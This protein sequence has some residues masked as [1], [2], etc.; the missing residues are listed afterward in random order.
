MKLSNDPDLTTSSMAIFMTS[1]GFCKL[2]LQRYKSE[3]ELA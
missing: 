2:D 3:Y 1:A